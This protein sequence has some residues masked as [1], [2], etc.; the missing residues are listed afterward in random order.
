M[1]ELEYGITDR[2]DAALYNMFDLT[3]TDDTS[4]GYAGFKIETRFRPSFPG[5]WFVDPVF[6]AEVQQLWRGDANQTYELKLILAKNIGK[7]N[8]SFNIAGEEE[9]TTDATWNLEIEH[10]EGVSYELAPAWK[11][12]LETFGKAEKNEMNEI[13]SRLWGGPALSWA[14]GPTG[15][16]RG[17]WVTVAAG[18]KI[19]GDDADAFYGR[20]IVGL[21]F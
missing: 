16:M 14:R 12:G 19:A 17:L 13:E 15:A 3:T 7:L 18:G 4:S 10:A 2:W 9:R 6:Y 21:Q 5:E 8:I 1:V 11:V 20:L